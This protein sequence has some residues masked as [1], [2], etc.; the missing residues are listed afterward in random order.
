MTTEIHR[1]SI[2][3]IIAKTPTPHFV[4]NGDGVC[5]QFVTANLCGAED[6]EVASF[7]VAIFEHAPALDLLRMQA[8]T[9]VE[10]TGEP[11]PTSTCNGFWFLADRVR[12]LAITKNG[13]LK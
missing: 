6:P 9:I 4:T 11:Q 5:P 10:L 2:V 7:T 3:G 13:A 1:A 8:G 12:A